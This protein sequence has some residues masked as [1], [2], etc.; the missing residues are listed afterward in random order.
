MFVFGLEQ[1]AILEVYLALNCAVSRSTFLH[2]TE[3]FRVTG[4]MYSGKRWRDTT[5]QIRKR[6][7]TIVLFRILCFRE[8]C[9]HC[10]VNISAIFSNF[11]HQEDGSCSVYSILEVD[12]FFTLYFLVLHYG[13]ANSSHIHCQMR[14]IPHHNFNYGLLPTMYAEW[15]TILAY[16]MFR[17]GS[18]RTRWYH[19]MPKCSRNRD[20]SPHPPESPLN[21]TQ[22]GYGLGDVKAK[23][24]TRFKAVER[25]RWNG[26]PNTGLSPQIALLAVGACQRSWSHIS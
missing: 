5:Y 22:R 18:L 17:T 10:K 1:M 16:I 26:N 15:R 9:L 23:L 8:N 13:I 12:N 4:N 24:L 14:V 25:W 3:V 7:F 2:H 6:V 20:A 21:S 19:W 11:L